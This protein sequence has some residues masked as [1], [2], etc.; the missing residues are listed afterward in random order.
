MFM[1]KDIDKSYYNGY[2]D[3]KSM[4]DNTQDK[5]GFYPLRQVSLTNIRIVICND[6]I[7]PYYKKKYSC[8]GISGCILKLI[9]DKS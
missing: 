1:E 7:C 2:R 6:D 3:I 4:L 8:F 9:Q 5:N